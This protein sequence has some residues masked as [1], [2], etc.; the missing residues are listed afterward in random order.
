MDPNYKRPYSLSLAKLP[1]REP[2]QDLAGTL[3]CPPPRGFPW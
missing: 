3:T 1:P 2:S